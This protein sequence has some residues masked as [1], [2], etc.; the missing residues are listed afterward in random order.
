MAKGPVIGPVPA[1]FAD[2]PPSAP[3]G[4]PE[5]ATWAM[6]MVGFAALGVALRRR[7]AAA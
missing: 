3:G 4:V 1:Q 7:S 6:L 5:P 2:P